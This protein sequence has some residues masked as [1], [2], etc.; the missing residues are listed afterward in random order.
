MNTVKFNGPFSWNSS[1][2]ILMTDCKVSLLQYTRYKV[3]STCKMIDCKVS[4]LQYTRCK[5]NW[6]C[7]IES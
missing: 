2:I 5:V 7:K 1:H 3:N 4:L 6:T